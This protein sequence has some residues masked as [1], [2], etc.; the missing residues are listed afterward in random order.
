VAGLHPFRLHRVYLAASRFE[1]ATLMRL[2]ARVLET[3]L[4]IKGESGEAEA[5]IY[6]LIAELAGRPA[7]SRAARR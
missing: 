7:P 6:E 1:A 3:E 4:R 2:P 5:A